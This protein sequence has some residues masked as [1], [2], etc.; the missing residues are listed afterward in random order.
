MVQ[1][2]VQRREH[3]QA[4]RLDLA[5]HLLQEAAWRE[6]VQGSLHHPVRP[7]QQGSHGNLVVLPCNA[8]M[9]TAWYIP[10]LRDEVIPTMQRDQCHRYLQDNAPCHKSSASM[11]FL[12][13]NN[14]QLFD[15]PAN[16]PDMN[17]QVM[18]MILMTM[19]IM[20]MILMT[21]MM[22]I[23]MMIGRKIRGV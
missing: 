9:N 11:G 14:I 1:G 22:M 21:M 3:L 19:M 15:W 20:M 5:P 13:C 17:P 10:V 6:P 8:M 7:P 4:Q 2:S 16:S 12:H 18:M 23:T